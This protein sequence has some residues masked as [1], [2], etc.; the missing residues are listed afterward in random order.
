MLILFLY[1]EID[2]FAILV[3]AIILF[4]SPVRLLNPAQRVFRTLLL[5]TILAILLDIAT[6]AAS[7]ASISGT[8]IWNYVFNDLYW[9][10]ALIPCYIGMLYCL[11]QI[12]EETFRKWRIIAAIPLF[13]GFF[14]IFLNHWT[15]WIF[16]ISSDG[17]YHRGLFFL[18]VGGIS[19]LH[20]GISAFLMFWESLRVSYGERTKFRM[21]GLFMFFPF[22]GSLL[23]VLVYGV[24]TIWPSITLTILMCSLFIQ[25]GNA[26][27]DALTRLN[28]RGR[29]DAYADW[30]WNAL[31][32][33]E[34]FWLIIMD[35]DHFK[36][37]NDTY[38]H[39]EGDRALARCAEALRAVMP[40]KSG[41]L[42]RIGGDEFAV[43]LCG[44]DEAFVTDFIR[45]AQSAVHSTCGQN[46]SGYC[47]DVSAGYAGTRGGERRDFAKLFSAAD[48]M[49]YQ[50]KKAEAG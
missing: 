43:I 33:S 38:G 24:S 8:R 42:A 12:S 2:I 5:F 39:A 41:F 14:M 13:Y 45:Q 37:I 48:E 7:G 36:K 19:Y 1:I 31:G 35:I 21:L 9:S 15:G 47:L 6:W 44:V 20:M 28:N 49:M 32:D 3:L 34:T 50:A 29:F 40:K 11:I 18:T 17:M 27:T 4:Y 16:T 30:K 26:T 25:N 10:A 23:Q 22:L 46:S